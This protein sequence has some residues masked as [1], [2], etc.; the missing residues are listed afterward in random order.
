MSNLRKVLD[1][2]KEHPE[3]WSQEKWHCGTSHCFL[4][5]A[6]MFLLGLSP[7]ESVKH[8]FF[9]A[10]IRGGLILQTPLRTIR[11]FLGVTVGEFTR[12]SCSKNTLQTLER[13]VERI[14]SE[15]RV[16]EMK[17]HMWMCKDD[18]LNNENPFTVKGFEN[19][20]ATLENI[21]GVPYTCRMKSVPVGTKI[22]FRPGGITYCYSKSLTT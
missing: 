1:W 5:V 8:D 21:Y 16:I 14:E 20:V 3:H 10:G 9:I 15:P 11:D 19:G 13:T 6:D 17:G 2:I 22:L 12:L 7:K 18:L 4:G